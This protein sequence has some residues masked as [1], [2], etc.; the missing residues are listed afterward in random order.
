MRKD[1]CTDCR[2]AQWLSHL[3]DACSDYFGVEPT[4]VSLP[5]RGVKT[6]ARTRQSVM[7]LL[8]ERWG[9]STYRIAAALER[10]RRTVSHG[11]ACA[12][13]FLTEQCVKNILATLKTHT[14][15]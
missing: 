14:P 4:A 10:D 11:V 15:S 5:T 9:W 7:Y 1:H 6:V 3:I 8:H 12:Q 2:Q 13:E